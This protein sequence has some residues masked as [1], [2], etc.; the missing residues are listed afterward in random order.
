MSDTTP[1]TSGSTP[2][3]RQQLDDLQA[4][5]ERM[6]ALPVNQLEDDSGPV[7]APLLEPGPVTLGPDGT[8]LAPNEPTAWSEGQPALPGLHEPRADVATAG[9]R[10]SV[11]TPTGAEQA[12]RGELGRQP[13]VPWK[14]T[15]GNA[16]RDQWARE[17]WTASL[18]GPIIWCNRVYDRTLVRLGGPG[19]WLRGSAGRT[20]VG[21]LGLLC[22][23]GAL[24]LAILDALGWTR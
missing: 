18:L 15:D 11:V 5:M 7:V 14:R 3:T 10:L 9:Y 22:L 2:P 17:G 1:R 24:T 8:T 21:W 4:L 20:L 12:A 19:R 6:L 16:A 23:A 13:P